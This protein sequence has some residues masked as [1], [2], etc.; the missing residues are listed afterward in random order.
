M[1]DRRNASF[2]SGENFFVSTFSSGEMDAVGVLGGYS[3]YV[4]KIRRRYVAFYDVVHRRG[5]L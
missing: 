5:W 4:G 2:S 3:V 1:E